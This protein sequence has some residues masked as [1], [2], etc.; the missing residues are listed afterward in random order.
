MS[1][2]KS[3]MVLLDSSV[4]NSIYI[5]DCEVCCRPIEVQI[6]FDNEQN[7]ESFSAADI[8]Q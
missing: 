4:Q 2:F 6:S 5:E 8:E 1:I 3:E 7:L